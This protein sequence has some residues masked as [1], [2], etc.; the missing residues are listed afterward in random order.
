MQPRNPTMILVRIARL[1]IRLTSPVSYLSRAFVR[2]A[3]RAA[4]ATC[5]VC[6]DIGS[7]TAPYFSDLKTEFGVECYIALDIAPTNLTNVVGDARQMPIAD[8]CVDLAVS[9]ESIQH[10]D[11]PDLVIREAARVLR[12]GGYLILTFPFLYPECDFRA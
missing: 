7:G 5:S 11:R 9:F 3:S 1:Y 2:R 10:V 8:A 4:K 6:L 12:P